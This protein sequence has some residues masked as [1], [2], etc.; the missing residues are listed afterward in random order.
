[1]SSLTTATYQVARAAAIGLVLAAAGCAG[2]SPGMS[3]G[4]SLGMAQ[5]GP[6]PE[7]IRDS[8]ALDARLADATLAAGAP[9]TTLHVVDAVLARDPDNI[10]AL[11]RRGRALMMLGRPADAA[12]SF[13]RAASLQ[14]ASSDALIGLARARAGEGDAKNAESAWRLALARLPGDTRVRI[15]LAIA[16]DLQE[17]H[18]EAQ[19]LYRAVLAGTPDDSAVRSDLGLSLALSG[20]VAEGVPLLRQ[21]AEGGF[22]ANSAASARARHNLAAGFVMAGD[23]PAARTLLSQDLPQAEVTMALAGLRQFASAR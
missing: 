11:L 4:A 6:G 23:E 1:M 16:L 8:P 3:V 21:A 10:A 15:G 19:T 20:H 18:A 14:P 12:T 17:R 5:A 22:G 7:A 2:N 13:A 9:D